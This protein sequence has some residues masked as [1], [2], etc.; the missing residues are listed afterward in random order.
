MNIF[1]IRNKREIET[2]LRRNTFL[3]IY[4][5]GDL[6]DSYWPH[7]TWCAI[8]NRDLI[9]ALA[10]LYIGLSLPVFLALTDRN[11]DAMSELL[12]SIADQLPERF[13]AH[14]SPGYEKIFERNFML[15]SH[16]L[17][18]K[19]ALKDKSRVRGG[20]TSRVVMISNDDIKELVTFYNKS[21]PG[22]WFEPRML[23]SGHYYGIRESDKMVSVAGVHVYSPEYRV[24]ALGNI[25]THPDYR[26]KGLGNAVTARLCQELLRSVDHVGLNVKSDNKI[27]VNC[28]QKLG[29]ETIAE[30]GEY[31]IEIK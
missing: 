19:M 31:M 4:G 24:A 29:F 20:D 10:L 9:E 25:A 27:A 3:N 30:Y 22:H 21:Y 16:G 28:Y 23:D 1:H 8:K 5:I 18:Y 12:N 17:H 15:K 6:D 11:S 13:Y 26:G 7:T 2:Y 14:L